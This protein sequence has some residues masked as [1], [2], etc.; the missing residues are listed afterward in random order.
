[1]TVTPLAEATQPMVITAHVTE[2]QIRAAIAGEQ[3][4]IVPAL[5]GHRIVVDDTD[6]GGR[7][8]AYH[9]EPVLPPAGAR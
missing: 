2:A 9:Y 7:R 1:M 6:L 3:P 8:V 4:V 5:A